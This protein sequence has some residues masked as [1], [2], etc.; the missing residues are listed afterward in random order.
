M[1]GFFPGLKRGGTQWTVTFC[2][3][4]IF[5]WG[6]LALTAC[7]YVRSSNEIVDD[8]QFLRFGLLNFP[9]TKSPKPER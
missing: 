5:V 8:Q 1:G 7:R 4:R 2:S 9:E 6:G 3:T